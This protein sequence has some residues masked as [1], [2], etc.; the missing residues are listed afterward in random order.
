MALSTFADLKSTAA[1]FLKRSDLTTQIPYFVQLCETRIYY[2]CYEKPFDIEPLRI[3]AMES[4]QYATFNA[5]QIALPSGFLQQRRLYI[6]GTP[7]QELDYLTPTLFWKNWI[8]STTGQPV[9]YTVEGENLILGPTPDTNYTGQM[10]F[11]K[12][13]DALVNDSDTNW[14]LTNAFGAYLHGTLAEA[15]RYTRNTEQAQIEHN[16]FA[17]IINSLNNSDKR[18]RFTGPWTARSDTGNP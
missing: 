15:Y 14:L 1:S 11:Y 2:G 8:S 10:L 7:N 16:A 12:K 18:D 6:S 13:F 4:S 9:E 3:R 17:G 5:Q